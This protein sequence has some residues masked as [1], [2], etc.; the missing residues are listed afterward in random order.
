MSQ[1]SLMPKTNWE[2]TDYEAA[3]LVKHHWRVFYSLN[4]SQHCY[5]MLILP[6]EHSWID[7][8]LGQAYVHE[9]EGLLLHLDT[10]MKLRQCIW[11]GDNPQEPS[12]PQSHIDHMKSTLR[13]HRPRLTNL[14]W[15]QESRK[16]Y[17][18][19]R[20]LPQ[21]VTPWCH[22]S[23]TPLRPSVQSPAPPSAFLLP[24]NPPKHLPYKSSFTT[25]ISHLILTLSAPTP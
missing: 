6:T 1:C 11:K 18:L 20:V 24:W 12:L 2:R 23:T 17:I 5:S 16:M 4:A 25:K 13:T 10:L 9:L 21:Q 22:A 15:P 14:Q 8:F 19:S 3:K 7:L